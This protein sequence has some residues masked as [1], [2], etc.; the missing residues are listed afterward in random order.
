MCVT[1][2]CPALVCPL[3]VLFFHLKIIAIVTHPSLCRSTAIINMLFLWTIL[4]I[5][6]LLVGHSVVPIL[7][8]YVRLRRDYRTIPSLP[9]SP[10]PF[11]GNLHQFDRRSEVFYKLFQRMYKSCQEQNKGLFILWYSIRPIIFLCSAAGL[12]VSDFRQLM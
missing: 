2:H 3:L 5:L 4:L 9:L 8:R 7:V 10:I 6:L 1:V 12:E 11:V